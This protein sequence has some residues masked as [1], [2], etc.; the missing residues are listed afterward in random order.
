ME[1]PET[2]LQF[3][4]GKFLRAFA[5]LFIDQANRSGQVIGCVVAVQS[6]GDSRA[7]LINRQ[8]G[9]YHVLVCGVADGTIVDQVEA[10]SSLSRALIAAQQ[11]PE[12]LQ[13]ARSPELRYVISNTA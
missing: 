6:T 1:L 3:G 5:D 12:V 7:H 11:W 2:V 10:V 4:T 9:R 8:H 13:V